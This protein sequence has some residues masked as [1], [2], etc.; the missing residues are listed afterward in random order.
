MQILHSFINLSMHVFLIKLIYIPF[1]HDFLILQSLTHI[2]FGYNILH[3]YKYFYCLKVHRLL[4]GFKFTSFTNSFFHCLSL[5]NVLWLQN[6]ISLYSPLNIC[7]C[8]NVR[9]A[10]GFL[11]FFCIL[12]KMF[13]YKSLVQ[14]QD[15]FL[16]CISVFLYPLFFIFNDLI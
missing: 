12:L 13:F 15:R 6:N 14:V 3:F 16:C 8:M 9:K 5:R 4:P 2:H 7:S 11:L 1:S 10:K